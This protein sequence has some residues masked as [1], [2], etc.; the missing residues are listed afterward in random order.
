MR[1]SD[2]V[3]ACVTG[4]GYIVRC[5]PDNDRATR[6]KRRAVLSGKPLDDHG[7]KLESVTC[8][9]TECTDTQIQISVQTGHAKLDLRCYT[10]ISGQNSLD[11]TALMQHRN[12]I[13][14]TGIRRLIARKLPFS[15]EHDAGQ[16]LVKPLDATLRD[17]RLNPGGDGGIH[18]DRLIGVAMH[19]CLRE[20]DRLFIKTVRACDSPSEPT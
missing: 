20:D 5:I 3:K 1:D 13:D 18:D 8:V 6:I 15:V 10:Q 17:I 14:R 7:R 11:E 4:T 16:H 12:G 2:N 9:I 19:A